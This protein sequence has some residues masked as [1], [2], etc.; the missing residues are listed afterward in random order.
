M[1]KKII[2]GAAVV[3]VAALAAPDQS[4]A[5]GGGW[6]GGGWHGGGWHGGGWHA[7]NWNNGF[8]RN[9][10]WYG[11]YGAWGAPAAI[12]AGAVAVGAAAAA[13]PYYVNGGGC[14][15]NVQVMTAYGPR[16]QVAKVC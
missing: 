9:G 1:L 13:A 15:R 11:G 12:A 16:W 7:G 8:R 4:Q 14:Y 5:R 2:M 10:R 3:A 6:H